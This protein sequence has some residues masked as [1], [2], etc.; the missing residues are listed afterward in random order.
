MKLLLIDKRVDPSTDNNY[1][2]RYAS[3]FGHYAAVRLL[4]LNERVSPNA[5]GDYAIRFAAM[6]GHVEVVKLLLKV[7]MS[8]PYLCSQ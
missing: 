4:L 8:R 6:N 5:L 2:I 3:R 7:W 1:P